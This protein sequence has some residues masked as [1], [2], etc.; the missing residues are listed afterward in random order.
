VLR[1]AGAGALAL[2]G[3]GSALTATGRALAASGGPSTAIASKDRPLT[4]PLY[5]DNKA[6]PSGR[7]P[8]KG[9]LVIYDWSDY[10]S[11]SVVSSFE[12]KYGVKAQVSNFAS[13]DEALNKIESGAVKA[14]VWVPDPDRMLQM[15][16]AKLIQPINHSYVPNLSTVIPAAA[17][18]WYDKGARYS[19]PN[20][21]NFYGVA[22]RKDL[23]KIDPASMKN[24]W[25]VF[26]TVPSRT[27]M[28]MVNADPYTT[29]CMALLRRGFTSL[30]TITQ[31]D[32]NEAVHD[33]Q[34][35]KGLKLQYTA[36]QP[37]AT[38]VEKMAYAYNGD[39]VQVPHF[40]PKSTPL[41][42]VG[43][44]YP[45]NGH[46]IILNDMWTIPRTAAHP[47]LAHLFIN[48]FLELQSAIENFRDVGYQT[49]LKELTLDKLVAAKIGP[50]ESIKQ[51]FATPTFQA[52]GIPCPLPT[53]QMLTWFETAFTTL[54]TG[55]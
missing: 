12:Q 36:F 34:K 3:A 42:D 38:G 1:R 39:M 5:S 52:N 37:I 40:L 11:P 24:P 4:L 32:I 51:A 15:V 6:I 13:I 10:L 26:W 8:E 27:P 29:I 16:E 41:T 17:D 23:I 18:P 28:G 55:G 7:S 43:F 33:L 47:V 35:L 44:Y 30:D 21:I 20:Y 53:T 25:N 22:W 31:S 54:S 46:G 2:A 14:D 19:T 45:P 50:A 48:H 9:P 49:M